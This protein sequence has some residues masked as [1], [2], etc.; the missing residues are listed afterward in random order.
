MGEEGREGG[1]GGG[2]HCTC[3]SANEGGPEGQER[4]SL[5]GAA[6]APATRRHQQ[7]HRVRSFSPCASQHT[8]LMWTP[9]Q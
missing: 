3:G 6:H 2:G 4:E 7:L 5:H 8:S 1:G 9:G